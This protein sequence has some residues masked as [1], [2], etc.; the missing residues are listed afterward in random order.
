MEVEAPNAASAPKW[1]TRED[2]GKSANAPTTQGG[3]TKSSSRISSYPASRHSHYELVPGHQNTTTKE[4]TIRPPDVRLV[5][6]LASKGPTLSDALGQMNMGPSGRDTMLQHLTTRD[7]LMIPDLF[8]ESSGF[9]MPPDPWDKGDGTKK[10]IYQRLVEE[11]HHAGKYEAS[12]PAGNAHHDKAFSID[13]DGTFNDDAGGLFKA[14]HKTN[15]RVAGDG[16]ADPNGRD[17]NGHL[18]VNDRDSR[19]QQAQARGEAPMYTAVHAR[20]EEWFQ[21]KIQ[22]KRYNHYRDM[23]NWKPFHHDSAALDKDA[24]KGKGGGGKGGGGKGGGGKGGGGKGGGRPHMC[25][26]QNMTVGVSFG[27]A[28]QAAFEWAGARGREG[29]EVPEHLHSPA[30]SG[31][32][33]KNIMLSLTVPDGSTYTF[34]RY[35]GRAPCRLHPSLPQAPATRAPR[36]SPAPRGRST[37]A[38][39][40][41]TSTSCGSMGSSRRR[42]RRARTPSH[43]STWRRVVS[44]LLRG[45]GST[46]TTS[47]TSISRRE[48]RTAGAARAAARATAAA[49]WTAAAVAGTTLASSAIVTRSAIAIEARAL[50]AAIGT[51][52]GTIAI[53]ARALPV[54]TATTV[55][56]IAIKARALRAATG[57]TATATLATATVRHEMATARTSAAGATAATEMAAATVS[58]IASVATLA[59]STRRTRT[60]RQGARL[61]LPSLARTR[62]GEHRLAR[63]RGVVSHRA[64]ELIQAVW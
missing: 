55:G 9:V 56:T 64:G 14:W 61:V 51:T 27:E 54:A 48:R 43:L 59:A 62:G 31:G 34:G 30:V 40:P 13:E 1:E 20:I 58:A 39:L 60:R 22:G 44:L 41:G 52:V 19:W 24:G 11:I 12:H 45:D 4:P 18:I 29:Y 8:E 5:T 32:S 35:G 23:T 37:L 7:V 16:L 10:T 26:S 6:A 46:S 47:W 42:L 33:H 36:A 63:T 17:G 25:E 50:P 28:R 3:G 21:M 49:A 57:T 38:I 2:T 53:E 15:A